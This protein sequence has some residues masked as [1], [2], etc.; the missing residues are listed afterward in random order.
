MG[1]KVNRRRDVPHYTVGGL[2]VID[3]LKAKMTAEQFEGF[4]LGNVFK[5]LFRY[6]HKG[7]R[8]DDLLK[9]QTY[10]GWLIEETKQ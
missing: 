7:D 10:L 2:E 1:T 3:I 9:A 8:L 4:L 6:R 5:Y